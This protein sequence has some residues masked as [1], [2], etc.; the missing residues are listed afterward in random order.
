MRYRFLAFCLSGIA[1]GLGGCH[2]NQA[3]AP[4]ET[5]STPDEPVATGSAVDIEGAK[6]AIRAE[7]R[8]VD[9]VYQPNDPV[10]WLIGVN[11]DGTPQFGYAEYICQII[12]EHGFSAQGAWVRIVDFRRYMADGDHHAASLGSVDCG[13]SEHRLP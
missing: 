7:K 3:P 13:T 10:Q 11:S 12:T 2:Y 8:V 1:V 9:V 5:A 4:T 6:A